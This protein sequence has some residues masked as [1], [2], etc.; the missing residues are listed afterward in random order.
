MSERSRYLIL[1][2]HADLITLCIAMWSEV[3]KIG[4]KFDGPDKEPEYWTVIKLYDSLES[5]KLDE[6]IERIGLDNTIRLFHIQLP[7]LS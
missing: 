2:R 6:I 7:K 3:P 1:A 4:E 5:R